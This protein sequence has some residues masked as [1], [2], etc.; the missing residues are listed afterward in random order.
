V[1]N[2]RA[3]FGGAAAMSFIA[4]SSTDVFSSLE[5]HFLKVLDAENWTSLL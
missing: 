2:H 1:P 5:D 3:E 4:K